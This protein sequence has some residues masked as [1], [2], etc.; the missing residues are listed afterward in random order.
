VKHIV[1]G[2]YDLTGG[3][4]V[5]GEADDIESSNALRYVPLAR[6]LEDDAKETEWPRIAMDREDRDIIDLVQLCGNMT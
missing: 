6:W 3:V 2:N 4:Y 5:L 1:S